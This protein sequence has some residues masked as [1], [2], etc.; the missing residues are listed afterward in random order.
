M[1]KGLQVPRVIL[2]PKSAWSDADDASF[3]ASSYGLTPDPWQLLVLGAWLG[4][5]PNGNWSAGR[6]GLAVPR[7][8]G[9]NGV[10]E[11]RELF[12]TVVLGEKFLHTAHEV[13]TARK[14]F[15]RLKYFFGS[16]V[17][18]P[19]AKFPELNALVREIRSTN[20]QE[21]I[22]LINGGAV[23]FVARSRGSGRGFT[24][25]V[26]VLD[27][28][29]ELTDE[30]LEAL[31]PTISSAPLGNPQTILTGTPPSAVGQ[32]EVFTRTRD[33]GVEGKAKRLAWHEWSVP[34]GVDIFDRKNWY[35]TNPALGTRLQVT[36]IED[37]LPPGMSPEG[38][39]R[40]RLGRWMT[41]GEGSGPFPDG[42]WAAGVDPL[43]AIPAGAQVVYCIDV[44]V[45]R[46][47]SYIGVAGLRA[48]GVAHVE[49]VARRDGTD[50]VAPWFAD[51]ATGT[52]PLSVVV[53]ARGAPASSLIPDLTAI[54]CLTVVEWGGPDLGNAT[55]KLYD[56]VKLSGVSVDGVRSGL[57]HLPQPV[58]DL[59]AASAVPKILFDGGM[60]W[61]RRRSPVDI[62]PLVVVTGALW[63]IGQAKSVFRSKY[64]SAGLVS[65]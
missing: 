33:A 34:A 50:W 29:Q 39:G 43:S 17:A 65:I 47:R 35:A 6:C 44:T 12:G 32:G 18:D 46:A 4:R 36:V 48:D 38:F 61:D 31:L 62:C 5:L 3:L 10:I 40:E 49:I 22:Y 7:Q 11:V 19:A 58:L 63:G 23:E 53:Q 30:H 26:L 55:A 1:L 59:A 21:A 56:L 9:K 60:A 42:L 25:D 54:E 24:V 13:K 15:V 16:C 20:G 27:E 51:R 2:E 28:A 14:A 64:E 41:P 37:E 52:N 45:D 57:A 8:N